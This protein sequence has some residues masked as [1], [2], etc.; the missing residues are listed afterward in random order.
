MLPKRSLCFSFILSVMI[1]IPSICQEKR[2]Y[3]VAIVVHEG[4]ELFDFAGPGE[5]FAAAGRI[6]DVVGINVFTVAPKKEP[7]TSQTFL[8]INPTYSIEDTPEI[9]ILVIPGGRTG[10][11]LRDEKFMAWVKYRFRE[12]DNLLTVCTGA[13]VPARL[14]MLDGLKA[15]THHGSITS[16]KKN[17]P[18]IEVIEDKKFI[19]N[20]K[21]ITS[22][23]VSSGTEG[24]LHVIRRIA[25]LKAAREVARY[26]EYDHWKPELGLVAYKNESLLRLKEKL[27]QGGDGA[28][29][30]TLSEITAKDVNYG[31]L[32]A[33]GLELLEASELE[34][35]S[36]IFHHLNQVF[37][38][39]LATYENLREILIKKGVDA[40]PTQ[41]VFF[42][43]IKEKGVKAAAKKYDTWIK[44]L[45]GWII[46]G[47]NAMNYLG[48]QYLSEKNYKEAIGI[49]DLLVKAYP[50]AWNAWDSR[51]E[52]YMR[53]GDYESA[54]KY[55]QKSLELNPDNNNAKEMIAKM[56]EAGSV[57]K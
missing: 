57:P 9:D 24:A 7:V 20:G 43:M 42:D 35:S 37:P 49:F 39:S 46:F 32:E 33:L 17:Y 48:Y 6:A 44:Q 30:Q 54:L 19:D 23:G 28:F 5:V 18:Q 55:Y 21:I 56:K 27:S 51:A 50:E 41:E 40:P 14:G 31:E 8:S 15:T 16:L 12:T 13:F 29:E 34:A 45:P 22:G 2:T 10:V 36:K 11:L 25:G 52:G 3:N 53:S 1:S 4:V 26:M 38:P 47:E